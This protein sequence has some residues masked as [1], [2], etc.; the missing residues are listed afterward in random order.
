M[1]AYQGKRTGE[2]A[3][4]RKLLKF[5]KDGD[6]LLGDAIFAQNYFQIMAML[7]LDNIDAVFEKNGA[8]ALQTSSTQ[9][10]VR[11]RILGKK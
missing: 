2:M 10:K 3:L 11:P 4:F 5:L 7:Q 1:A 6:I 9:E 8:T